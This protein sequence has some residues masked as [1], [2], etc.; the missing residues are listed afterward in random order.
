MTWAEHDRSGP[1]TRYCNVVLFVPL[2][3]PTE[4]GRC[5]GKCT[6]GCREIRETASGVRPPHTSVWEPRVVREVYWIIAPCFIGHQATGALIDE[7]IVLKSPGTLSSIVE[8][9]PAPTHTRPRAI[10]PNDGVVVDK[11]TRI[12]IVEF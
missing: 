9:H 6:V 12:L 10:R 1:R 11:L 8:L 5:C 2:I 7:D 3:E 4:N